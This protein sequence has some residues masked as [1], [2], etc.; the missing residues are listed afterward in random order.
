MVGGIRIFSHS[1]QNIPNEAAED[2]MT[3][4]DMKG[5]PFLTRYALDDYLGNLN[6][7]Y[8]F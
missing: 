1:H 6:N 5:F 7:S 8:E 2:S 3:Q 4:T